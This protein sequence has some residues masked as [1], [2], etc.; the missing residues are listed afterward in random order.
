MAI[1]L[2]MGTRDDPKI[3]INIE[4]SLVKLFAYLTIF[5]VSQMVNGY[6]HFIH[7]RKTIVLDLHAV[8]DGEW[9]HLE[10]RWMAQRQFVISLDYGQVQVRVYLYDPIN[11]SL[12][13]LIHAETG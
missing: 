4:V 5:L 2:G 7:P 8:N 1:E 10:M 11:L 12:I 3:R 13:A 9:H 6:I